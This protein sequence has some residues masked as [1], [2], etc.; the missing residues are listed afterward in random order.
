MHEQTDYVE[1]L[2]TGDVVTGQYQCSECNYGVSVRRALPLC[3]MCGGRVW[4]EQYKQPDEQL[5]Q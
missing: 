4:E 1:F 2:T 5:L 3:P